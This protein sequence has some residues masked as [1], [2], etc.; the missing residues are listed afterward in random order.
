MNTERLFLVD[1]YNYAHINL[2]DEFERENEISTKTSE[3]LDNLKAELS[4]EEYLKQKR[5][6]NDIEESLFIETNK[7]IKDSCHIQGVKD[8]KTCTITFAPIKT[9]LRN[10]RLITLAT[11][12]AFNTLDMY[13][14]FIKVSKDDKN[15][16]EN[17]NARGFESLGEEEGNLIFLKEKEETKVEQRTK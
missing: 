6:S 3:F 5:L 9:K 7:K 1:P 8:I 4:K 15:M 16:I 17:L 14:V 2:I 13:E 12:Y 10:R 11:D